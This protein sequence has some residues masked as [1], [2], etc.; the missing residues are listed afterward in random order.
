MNILKSL[1]PAQLYK[2]L[3]REFN[4]SP[5]PV[6]TALAIESS[7]NSIPI[8]KLDILENTGFHTNLVVPYYV[9]TSVV[10]KLIWVANPNKML[11]SY[12]DAYFVSDN[13]LSL[14]SYSVSLIKF[15][16]E[17]YQI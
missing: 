6:Y 9:G 15:K 14:G 2:Y 16:D 5:P 4:F 3:D 8:L 13:S 17:L 10:K 12:L 11:S 1:T 7:I